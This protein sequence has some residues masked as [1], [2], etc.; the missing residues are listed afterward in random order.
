MLKHAGISQP[1]LQLEVPR[2]TFLTSGHK[3]K[4][5]GWEKLL[6]REPAPAFHLLLPPAWTMATVPEVVQPSVTMRW[7]AGGRKPQARTAEQR[8]RNSLQLCSY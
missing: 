3:Q 5:L 4:L 2:G 1:A 6:G 8:A 7:R